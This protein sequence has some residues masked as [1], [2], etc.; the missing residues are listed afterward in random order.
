M[1]T[2]K[3]TTKQLQSAKA[4]YYNLLKQGYTQKLA[5]NIVGVNKKTGGIWAKMYKPTIVELTATKQSIV[6]IL[7]SLIADASVNPIHIKS[8]AIALALVSK[9]INK[10][11]NIN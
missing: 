10:T 2:Q 5:S 11:L 1:E 4:K 6:K 9:K 3:R 7:T 8:F